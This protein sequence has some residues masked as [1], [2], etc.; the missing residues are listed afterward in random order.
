MLTPTIRSER[1]LHG[2]KGN[3]HWVQVTRDDNMGGAAWVV[4]LVISHYGLH[5]FCATL[6]KLLKTSRKQ[7]SWSSLDGG[8]GATPM[9]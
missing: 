5:L 7:T 8:A 4:W 3:V 1:G 9:I 6:W 2:E